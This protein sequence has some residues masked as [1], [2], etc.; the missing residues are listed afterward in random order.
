[1]MELD[2]LKQKWAEHDRKLEVNIR[3]TRQLLSATKMN[4]ARSALRRLAV[5]L[6]LES[7]VALASLSYLDPLSATALRQRGL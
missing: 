5:F 2:E 1:M 4:R 3:L 6:A 7:A